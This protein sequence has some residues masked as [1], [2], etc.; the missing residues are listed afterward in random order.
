MIRFITRIYKRPNRQTIYWALEEVRRAEKNLG[1]VS[2]RHVGR[3][4]N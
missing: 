4:F 2:Y 3:D 1:H